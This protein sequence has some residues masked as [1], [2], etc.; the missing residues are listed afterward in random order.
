MGGGGCVAHGRAVFNC[1]LPVLVAELDG[2]E[3]I[4]KIEN[5]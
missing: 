4:N 2:S 1:K 3:E 5:I